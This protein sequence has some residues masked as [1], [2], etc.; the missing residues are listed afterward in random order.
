MIMMHPIPLCV[1]VNGRLSLVSPVLAEVHQRRFAAPVATATTSAAANRPH[2]IEHILAGE[3][4]IGIGLQHVADQVAHIVTDVV[5]VRLGEL[6]QAEQDGVE[7]QL[8][9]VV[10]RHERREAAQQ[11]VQNDAGRPDVDL[12]GGIDEGV[13]SNQSTV[14]VSRVYLQSVAGLHQDLGR[15]V[16]RCAAHRQQGL[17]DLAGQPKVGQLEFG[18]LAVGVQLDEQVLRLDVAMHDAQRV[19]VGHGGGQMAHHDAR[20]RFG[21]ARGRGDRIEEIAAC[22]RCWM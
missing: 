2:V 6:V 16:R 3:P 15:H 20:M 11:N 1:H 8:L 9:L 19:Q 12:H 14:H 18:H 13:R 5:P 4:Q 10:R 7:Q 22:F 21:E 17:H